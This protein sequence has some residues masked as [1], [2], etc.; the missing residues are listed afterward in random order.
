MGKVTYRD[1]V[2]ILQVIV[3]F[4]ALFCAVMLCLRHGFKRSS[5]WVLLVTFSA[6]RLAGAISQLVTINSPTNVHA[7]TAAIICDS[8]GLSPLTLLSVGL[9]ARLNRFV[10]RPVSV[11]IFSLLS[12]ISVVG[13][14]L[15]IYGGVHA[16]NTATSLH[17]SINGYSKAAVLIFTAIYVVVVGIF[18]ILALQVGQ[19]ERGERRLVLAVA[20]S[21]PFIATRL[22]Y[23]LI[24]DFANSAAFNIYDGNTTIY[25]CMAVLEEIIV[26]L[27]CIPIGFSLKKLP[28]DDAEA[29]REVVLA[30][31]GENNVPYKEG[32]QNVSQLPRRRQR[33]RVR[34]GPIH[35]LI[36]LI[37]NAY[38]DWQEKKAAKQ[39]QQSVSPAV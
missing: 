29:R 7:I 12:L 36:A 21:V 18:V 24:A 14:A 32:E 11:R 13:L 35:M 31:D 33:R 34:G 17:F 9:L 26:V 37:G 6:L 39:Q 16:A 19:V 27:I 28:R 23:A 25:L 22:I 3:Y 30:Q 1:G 10:R 2:A 38:D 8:I 20:L 15:G 4:P 5:G